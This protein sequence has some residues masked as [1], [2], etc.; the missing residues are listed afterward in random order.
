MVPMKTE[1]PVAMMVIIR[2][3]LVQR[4]NSVSYR[5]FM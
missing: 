4:R 1:I 5:S 3:F 2:L